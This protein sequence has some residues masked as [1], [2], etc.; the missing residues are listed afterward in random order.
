M[1]HLPPAV[2]QAHQLIL[3]E[4]ARFAEVLVDDRI[5]FA[6]EASFALQHLRN[7]T[8]LADT[9][10]RNPDSLR[11]AVR[12]VA[13]I[14]ISLNPADKHAY[15]VPRDKKVCL[16]ISYLGLVHLATETGS[17]QW[18]QAKHVHANDT[19]QSNGIDK[20]PTHQYNTFGNRGAVVGAYVVAKTNGGDYLTTEMTID[21]INAIKKR[22][23]SASKGFSPWKSDEG[24][25]Q[26][27]TVIKRAYKMWPKSERLSAAV[28]YLNSHGQGIDFNEEK[29]VYM[30]GK[31]SEEATPDQK[32]EYRALIDSTDTDEQFF[33]QYLANAIVKRE[34]GSFDDLTSVEAAKAIALLQQK[35]NQMNAR[36]SREQAGE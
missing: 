18:V 36:Q 1:N 34:M 26:L 15:L 4:E 11:D 12:N 8:F 19:Y 6:R 2:Q 21:E 23:P 33:L 17:V 32:R 24:Q 9:A 7:N 29:R 28:E 25:M 10:S 35:K 20:A 5:S 3:A 31:G 14:G 30:A 13:A 16:D 27:K 22:S